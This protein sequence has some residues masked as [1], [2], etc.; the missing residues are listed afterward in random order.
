MKK[1]QQKDIA[2]H[3][4]EL[5]AVRGVVAPRATPLVT[6]HGSGDG[7]RSTAH[8][9]GAHTL[10][11][12]TIPRGCAEAALLLEVAPSLHGDLGAVELA[13]AVVAALVGTCH[14]ASS[15]SGITPTE[16][17]EVPEGICGEDE[18]PNR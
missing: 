18:V 13:V 6:K 2:N 4:Q 3:T 11:P 1:E 12:A 9:V 5:I 14:G 16:V 8:R 17:V 7:A 10:R 15:L